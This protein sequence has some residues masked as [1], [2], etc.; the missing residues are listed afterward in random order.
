MANTSSTE[1]KTPALTPFI[2]GK[3]VSRPLRPTRLKIDALNTTLT[4]AAPFDNALSLGAFS[5][6][7]PFITY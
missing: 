3:V 1:I 4:P 5:F 2:K 6:L 7:R